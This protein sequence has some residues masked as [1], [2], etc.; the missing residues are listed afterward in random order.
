MKCKSSVDTKTI[1]RCVHAHWPASVCIENQCG[2]E[3]KET[4]CRIET[5]R[6]PY[7]ICLTEDQPSKDKVRRETNPANVKLAPHSEKA[8]IGAI[9]PF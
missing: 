2:I 1:T 3:I 9:T 5:K 8:Q 4:P 7:F 6:R